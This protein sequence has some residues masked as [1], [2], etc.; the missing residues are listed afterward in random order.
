MT[1]R[2]TA[3]RMILWL[4]TTACAVTILALSLQPAGQSSALSSGLTHRILSWFSAYRDLP[5]AEQTVF[6][7]QVQL[8]VREAAHVAEFAVLGLF[9]SWLASSYVGGKFWQLSLPST[10]LFAIVDEC[11][12]GLLAEGRAFQLIDLAKDWLG[13]ALGAA[14]V[15]VGIYVKQK[16]EKQ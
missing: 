3:Y 9:A 6:L 1:A 12:Q 2:K 10:A 11:A 4:L 8:L 15:A 5:I 13:C 7:G 14:V 16:T